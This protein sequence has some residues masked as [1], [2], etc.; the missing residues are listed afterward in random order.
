MVEEEDRGETLLPVIVGV[1]GRGFDQARQR[2]LGVDT[3]VID[4]RRRRFVM[5]QRDLLRRISV[6]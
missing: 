5:T 3:M 2:T 1:H 4:T 6:R